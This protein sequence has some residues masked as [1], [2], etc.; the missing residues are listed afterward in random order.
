MINKKNTLVILLILLVT[1]S[2][3]SQN[4][5][6]KW[7]SL[8]PE[9][10]TVDS[11]I[12]VYEKDGKAYAKIIEIKD[13][14]KRAALCTYC[15]DEKKNKPVLGMDILTGLEKDDD[16]WSGGAILDPRNGK[17]YQCYIK[18]VN[19]NKLKLRGYIG[20]SLFGK[21]EYMERAE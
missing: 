7:E 10:R 17:I 4:I 1:F 8:D 21:T 3:S 6:G 5:F 19:A 14:T 18:L 20:I 16:E 15:K 2:I 9:T 12:E 13:E 11:V